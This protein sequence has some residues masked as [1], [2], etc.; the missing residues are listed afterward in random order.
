MR[1]VLQIIKQPRFVDKALIKSLKLDLLS[2]EDVTKFA[3]NLR[4]EFTERGSDT[5]KS[6]EVKGKDMITYLLNVVPQLEKQRNTAGTNAVAKKLQHSLD[7]Q[8]KY[9]GM[10]LDLKNKRFSDEERA[11]RI[12]NAYKQYLG[13]GYKKPEEKEKQPPKK[14]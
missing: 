1:E 9:L 4:E 7:S 14:H 12:V 3:H 13:R 10:L 8:L 6:P 5:P 11:R 2:V